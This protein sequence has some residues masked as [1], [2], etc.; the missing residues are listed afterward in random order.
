MN[1][2]AEDTAATDLLVAGARAGDEAAFTRLVAAHHAEMLR[3]AFV[4]T[5]DA[6]V[7]SDA[8]QRAWDIAWRKL[9]R[10]REP[11]RVRSWLV[12]IAANE[13]RQLSRHQRR[14]SVVEIAVGPSAGDA[15]D[16]T[17]GIGRLDLVNAL[18]RLK[19]EDRALLAMRYVA[20][21]DSFEIAAARGGSASGTRAR[22]ARVLAQ[23]RKEL[24]HD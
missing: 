16:P 19:P 18:A 23:L 10:L 1:S 17:A 12:A 22:I 13:A 6:D 3:V 20:G 2:L 8:A 21:F 24:D 4:I 11:E 14:R 9:G 7:A 5:G 15:G